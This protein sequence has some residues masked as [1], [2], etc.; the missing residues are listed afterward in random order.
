VNRSQSARCNNSSVIDPI[1]VILIAIFCICGLVSF[2]VSANAI[3]NS[4]EEDGSKGSSNSSVLL[5]GVDRFGVEMLYPSK[6]AGQ[7]WYMD[8]INPTS[9]GRFNPQ[10]QITLNADGSW[11]MRS[12]KVRMYVY[13]S[14]GYNPHQ[15]TSDGGQ[16]RVAARGFMGSPN[17]WRD[18]EITGY[19]KLNQF[20]END[21]FVWYTRGGKHSDSDQCQGSAYKGNLFYHGETQF[22]KEQWHVSYAKSPTISATGS[23]S[24]KWI[25]FK[26][27]M[28]NF[29]TSE[30]KPVVKLENWIDPNSDGKNW[31]KV[32]EGGD[33]GKWGRSG[34]ECQVKADQIITWG[35][36]IA[37]FRWDFAQDVDFRD[38]SVREITGENGTSGGIHYFTGTSASS[39][40]PKF[41]HSITSSARAHGENMPLN[42]A[43]GNKFAHNT[44]GD[45]SLALNLIP[46]ATPNSWNNDA[47]G[48]SFDQQQASSGTN[49]YILWVRGDEDNTDLYLKISHDGGATFGNTINLSNNPASL[50][51]HPKIVASGENVYV[52]WE[53]DEGKSGNSD[54]FF[55]KSSDAGNS[56]SGKS[57]LSN[58]PSG[59]GTP[60][61]SVSAGGEV[62]VAWMGTS[63][64]STD[65]FLAHSDDGN[66]FSVPEN[67]S[68]DPD[69]SFNPI[70]SVNG[71][72]VFVQWTDQDE[73]GLTRTE[74][75]TLPSYDTYDHQDSMLANADL[76]GALNSTFSSSGILLGNST[77]A[78]GGNESKADIEPE[79][80]TDGGTLNQSVTVPSMDKSILGFSNSSSSSSNSGALNATVTHGSN[81]DNLTNTNTNTNTNAN[82]NAN[83]NANTNTTNNMNTNTNVI[84]I[85]NL[86]PSAGKLIADGGELY[87]KTNGTQVDKFKG[88]RI[89]DLGTVSVA[90]G[91]LDMRL[92][93]LPADVLK[94]L[95]AAEDG[96]NRNTNSSEEAPL[97]SKMD[98]ELIS[99]QPS[100]NIDQ[101][102]SEPV[103]AAV[104]L[105]TTQSSDSIKAERDLVIQSSRQPEPRKDLKDSRSE[106]MKK[107]PNTQEQ[108]GQQ[109]AKEGQQ[110]QQQQRQEQS[111]QQPSKENGMPTKDKKVDN[112]SAPDSHVRNGLVSQSSDRKHTEHVEQKKITNLQIQ[113][114]KDEQKTINQKRFIQSENAKALKKEA[115]NNVQGLIHMADAA[116]TNARDLI[117]QSELADQKVQ[118]TIEEFKTRQSETQRSLDENTEIVPPVLSQLINDATTSDHMAKIAVQKYNDLRKAADTAIAEFTTK[119]K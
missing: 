103:G 32:Y 29:A 34:T 53:D 30:G 107:E 10:D 15:I 90:V 54:I 17:D 52:V 87:T 78:D 116:L 43:L 16:S 57:N 108:Q 58:D 41:G 84:A 80:M 12:D 25:G 111:Q 26:F 73:N 14:N 88:N 8:M 91:N 70:L 69:I 62:Y 118:D 93:G 75:K 3:N 9:D 22:S 64:D 40:V 24:G 28:Y 81:L 112:L 36:P 7:E 33:A 1:P 20:T 49:L 89:L 102:Q 38:L 98:Q 104:Q 79:N 95:R 68:N 66:I 115:R 21:D 44:L 6:E 105:D 63:P 47:S 82:A 5:P 85:D 35:G 2:S 117:K 31:E 94:S 46:S 77:S 48:E 19:V 39:N 92:K 114:M 23:L 67:L 97:T 83:A 109:L 50:S 99:V 86:S 100:Q 59:S 101:K 18:V 55:I 74:S 42:G 56:F 4:T 96:L 13:T 71:T 106:L 113:K 11:K 76:P 110:Q 119:F 45:T 61:L 65:I 37:S 72:H 60:Q 51:Y 27:V